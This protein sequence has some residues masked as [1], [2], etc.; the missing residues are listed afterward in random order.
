MTDLDV[1]Q[2]AD[3][4]SNHA[5]LSSQGLEKIAEIERLQNFLLDEL[6]TLSHRISQVFQ[7]F[8]YREETPAQIPADPA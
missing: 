2:S 6:D 7:T 4:D 8:G 3:A 1:D 5:S